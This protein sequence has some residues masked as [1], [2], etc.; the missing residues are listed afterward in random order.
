MEMGFNAINMW[1]ERRSATFLVPCLFS[2]Y[3]FIHSFSF[4]HPPLTFAG[5]LAVST[6]DT[7]TVHTSI[8]NITTALTLSAT[9]R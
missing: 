4:F 2:G 5:S 8:E 9:T 3:C 1:D 7:Y 6:V